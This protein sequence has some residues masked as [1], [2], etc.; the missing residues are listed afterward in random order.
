MNGNHRRGG[1]RLLAWILI[2]S[3]GAVLVL[4]LFRAVTAFD[5]KGDGG[6]VFAAFLLLAAGWLAGDF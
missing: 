1:K 3:G 5:P 4:A 2:A 6:L